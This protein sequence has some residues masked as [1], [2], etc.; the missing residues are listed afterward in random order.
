MAQE[1]QVRT[2][3]IRTDS[4]GA[5]DIKDISRSLGD[6]N[7]QLKNTSNAMTSMNNLAASAIGA[8]IFGFGVREVVGM[9]DSLILLNGRLTALTGSASTAKEIMGELAGVSTMVKSSLTDTAEAYT[10]IAT[11]TINLKLPTQVQLDLT[12]GLLQSFRLSGASAQ[13]AAGA[14][15]QF[16][17]A[18][19]FGKLSGQELRSVTSQNAIVANILANSIKNTGENIKEFAEKG[20]FTTSFLLRHLLPAF[21]DLDAQA[22]VMSQTFGQTM[23]LAMNELQKKA[24]DLNQEFD[25]NGKFANFMKWFLEHGDE[26]SNIMLSIGVSAIPSMVASMTKLAALLTP[27]RAAFGLFAA[28]LGLASFAI[29]ES[30]HGVKGL[31]TELEVLPRI[32]DLIYKQNRLSTMGGPGGLLSHYETS[33]LTTDIKN[34]HTEISLMRNMPN[35]DITKKFLPMNNLTGENIFGGTEFFKRGGAPPMPFQIPDDKVKMTIEQKIGALNVLFNKGGMDVE[36]YNSK[37][38]KLQKIEFDEKITKGTMSL[39]KMNRQLHENELDKWNRLLE[40]GSITLEQ[41]YEKSKEFQIEELTYKFQQ[42]KKSLAEYNMELL[43]LNDLGYFNFKNVVA[44]AGNYVES[45]GNRSTQI[46]NMV[47]TT[48]SSLG[49]SIFNM[50]KKGQ[51]DFSEF[52]QSV[53]DDLTRI[54][55][56][57]SIIEPLAKSITGGG[58]GDFFGSLFSSGTVTPIAG[59]GSRLY[60][61]PMPF[62]NGDVFSSPTTFG[63]GNGKMGVMGER[64][65][66]A[67]MPLKRGPGGSL[68]VGAVTPAVGVVINNYT[69]AKVEARE[70]TDRDGLKQIEI[71]VKNTVVKQMANGSYDRAMTTNYGVARKGG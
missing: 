32:F 34:L 39:E 42:G 58:I 69:S 13:E 46:A 66:E 62:A 6:M 4:K 16:A 38:E 63:F 26:V 14:T 29:L 56:R 11:A 61:S 65:P 20:G 31:V 40:A 33:R 44:G 37:L 1:T 53:L 64:G 21:K 28:G 25:L 45:V 36:E 41:F 18:L 71:I 7:K 2:I 12:K 47:E 35:M 27:M 59:A 10:R 23:T 8:S 49:D 57:M 30:T 68:G 24:Y 52:T 5:Q 15:I 54:L 70:T 3:I 19:S 51:Y 60:Q 67:V 17:Q 50:T 55:I 9:A 43:R 48:F 22:N